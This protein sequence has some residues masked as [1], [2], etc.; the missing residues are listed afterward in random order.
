MATSDQLHD[1]LRELTGRADASFRDGQ[2]E[3]VQALVERRDRVLVVQRTGW[4]KS[5]VYFLATHLLRQS[6]LGPTLLI[7]PL[8]ALMRNQ[9]EAAGRLGLRCQTVN[10]SSDTTVAE[11]EQALRRDEVDL[12]VISPERLAN[13]DF[14]DRIMPLVGAR[15]GLIV[16]DEVHCISDWGH[17]FRPDYRRIGRILDRLASASVPILGCTATANDRVVNDVADQLGAKLTTFRGPLRRDGLALSTLLLDRQAERLAWL[18]ETIPEIE[19]S[20][21]VYCLTVRD[22]ENVAAWLGRRGLARAPSL[23]TATNTYRASDPPSDQPYSHRHRSISGGR[24][25]WTTTTGS[26]QTKQG[27]DPRYQN[28][29]RWLSVGRLL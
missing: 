29:L 7:S 28:R 18:S 9:I 4:G 1:A 15:P 23:G 3:A 22:A 12:V 2:H 11:L 26:P 20:G 21:I 17:D 8:L 16:I 6:G 19:G 14:G 27:A 13:P 24:I 10:S 5:A 25:T